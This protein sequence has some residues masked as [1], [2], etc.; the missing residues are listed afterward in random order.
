MSIFDL[1]NIPSLEQDAQL[2]C[3]ICKGIMQ[4]KAKPFLLRILGL[5]ITDYRQLE[6]YQCEECGK[7]LY[8]RKNSLHA[9]N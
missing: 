9:G 8:I 2:R 4:E 6:K 7:E 3:S 1:N 5:F